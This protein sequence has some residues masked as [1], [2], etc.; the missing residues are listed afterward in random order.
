MTET[1][2]RGIVICPKFASTG[3]DFELNCDVESTA[4]RRFLLY[5]D[6][7]AY[8][9]PN[10]LGKPNFS[11]L[12]DLGFLSDCGVLSLHDIPVSTADISLGEVPS[13]ILMSQATCL[14]SGGPRTRENPSGIE[15]LG[16]PAYVWP[17]LSTFAQLKVATEV[18]PLDG[19]IW[20][21]GQCNAQLCTTYYPSAVG[22][23]LEATLY[24][25]LPIPVDETPLVEIMEFRDRR[26]AEL[27]QLRHAMDKLHDEIMSQPDSNRDLQQAKEEIEL[28]LIQIHKT[29]Q[30]AGIRTFFST[31]K[32]FLSVRESTALTTLLG[33]LGAKDTGLPLGVGAL[34]GLGVNSIITF[35]DRQLP[36][37]RGLPAELADFA[38]LYDIERFWPGACAS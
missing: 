10:G 36:S 22:L 14:M 24:A 21:I 3:P 9:Y 4:L 20:T 34:A 29:L 19:D 11:A 23:L 12:R 7:I 25:A 35:A 16:C 13:P 28:A 15:I 2:K 38:Y 1:T 5:W 33:I 27:I 8:A 32:V 31:L 26:K 30:G 6:K 18:A 17:Q 37:S